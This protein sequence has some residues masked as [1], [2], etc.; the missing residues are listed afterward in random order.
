ML[1]AVLASFPWGSSSFPVPNPNSYDEFLQAASVLRGGPPDS[2][3]SEILVTW[4]SLNSESYTLVRAGLGKSSRVAIAASDQWFS[5][6]TNDVYRLERLTHFM[7]ARAKIAEIEGHGNAAFDRYMEAYRFAAEIGRGGLALDFL[8]GLSCKA[9]VLR[10]F[11]SLVPS[12]TPL[13]ANHALQL[14]DR[15]ENE[16]EQVMVIDKRS[17]RWEYATYGLK[18]RLAKMDGHS[19][20]NCEESLIETLGVVEEM[21]AKSPRK[22]RKGVPQ[23]GSRTT[24]E[25]SR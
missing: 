23:T 17:H 16:T 10:S 21:D 4:V 8:T 11:M 20:R 3:D 24:S 18:R 22:P 2:C 15:T 13:Q 14:I 1:L 25:V 7:I 9:L 12:L 6:H 19:R 5:K